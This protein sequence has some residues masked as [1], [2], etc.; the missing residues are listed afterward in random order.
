MGIT[1][2]KKKL[3]VE[4]NMIKEII[5]VFLIS[6]LFFSCSNDSKK[7]DM[8]IEKDLNQTHSTKLELS[9][10]V[11]FDK[12]YGS[13][14]GSAIGD[15]MGLPTEM[16]SRYNRMVEYGFVDSLTDVRI[17]PSPE[18]AWAFNLPPGSTSDDTRWKLLGVKY[19]IEYSNSVHDIG[20]PSPYSFA[21]FIIKAYEDEIQNLKNTEGFDPKF[22]ENNLQRMAFLQEW[23]LVAKPFAE[24]DL[25][26]YTTALHRFYGGDIVCAGMLYSP[27]LGLPYP[28]NPRKAYEVAFRLGIFDQGYARDITALSAAMV[29]AAMDSA[30]TSESILNVFNNIDPHDFFG[31]RIFS[32]QAYY[33]YKDAIYISHEARKIDSA[34]INNELPFVKNDPIYAVQLQKAFQLL[35]E[36]QMHISPHSK[37]ILLITLTAMIFTEF[38]FQ[39]SIE[40]CV[41]YGRDND[42]HAAVVG[43]ILGAYYGFNKLPTKLAQK[44]ISVNKKNIGIDLKELSLQLTDKIYHS[45]GDQINN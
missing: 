18:G 44:V 11:L 16:W 37:E 41:N 26:K 17:N 3:V 7:Q 39:K 23:A 2:I 22:Y 20:G 21:K 38:D 24:N 13:L 27:V 5:L 25:E 33:A 28:A 45:I 34:E 35:D 1:F 8:V 15:A 43:S 12:I 40:F 42:T 6:I 31:S 32:R 4:I 9:K 19:L 36:K 29:A 14:V 10:E 30:A